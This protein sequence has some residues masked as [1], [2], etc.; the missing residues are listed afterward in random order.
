MKLDHECVREILL[1]LEDNL[2]LDYMHANEIE[3]KDYPQD[4]INY[5]VMRLIEADY[6]IADIESADDEVD[7]TIST[8]TWKGHEF[9]DTV[10]DKEVWK[11]TKGFLSK[12]ASVS[13][14]FTEK[15]AADVITNMLTQYLN[16]QLQPPIF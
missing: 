4:V 3:L 16:G 2:G 10:R 7:I 5:S 8:I 6:L 12:F 1:H 11:K 15:V 14:Q 9:L 13:L